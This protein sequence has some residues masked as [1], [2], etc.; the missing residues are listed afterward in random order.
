[1]VND[2]TAKRM[3]LA[4]RIA[5]AYAANPN[6]RAVLLAGS[7]ARGVADQ[8]SDIEIDVFWSQPPTEDELQA[9][10]ERAGATLL[11][12]EADANEWA[13]GFFIEG[14]KVD[15]SQFLVGTIERWLED[16][17]DRADTEVE[18]QLLIAAVQHALPLHGADLAARWRAKAAA[19]P[20]ELSRAMVAQH[21]AFR[22]RA[23]L[24]MFAARDDLLIL[25]KGL[26]A[27]EE[28]IMG[29]LLGLNRLYLAHP[30]HKWMDWQIAQMSVAP[31]DLA[32]RL[33]QIL[34]DEPRAAV[35]A[36][37][38]LIEEIFALVEQHLPGFDTSAARAEFGQPRTLE[39]VP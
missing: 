15:T 10:I 37:H 38:V 27:V 5:P 36:I 13:D 16:V 1:M 11:Y 23:L 33:K 17:V 29:V 8:F 26:V 18:K 2:P 19:Y 32:R 6:V 39:P 35:R 7:V 34:R 4:Q 21:L 12:R 24:E 30:S 20:D 9:P 28:L 14:I 31:P 25:Y 3:A 22:P